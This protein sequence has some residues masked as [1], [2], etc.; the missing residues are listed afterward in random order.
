MTETKTAVVIR[1]LPDRKTLNGKFD[2]HCHTCWNP[3]Y[4]GWINDTDPAGRCPLGHTRADQCPDA[5]G[6]AATSAA[7]AKLRQQG[8][9]R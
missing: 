9:V 6:R 1:D 7:V 3:V 2:A 5:M 8:L 4:S